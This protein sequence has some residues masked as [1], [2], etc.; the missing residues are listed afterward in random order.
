M[1]TNSLCGEDT[2]LMPSSKALHLQIPKL[3]FGLLEMA[4]IL[5]I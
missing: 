2:I 3:E 5:F 1:K 4:N